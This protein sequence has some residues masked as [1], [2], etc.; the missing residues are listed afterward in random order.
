MAGATFVIVTGLGLAAFLIGRVDRFTPT[1]LIA[2]AGVAGLAVAV[3]SALSITQYRAIR[4]LD[5]ART[6]LLT[7]HAGLEIERNEHRAKIHDA[8]AMTAAMAAAAHALPE[9][10][11]AHEVCRA[12]TQ[13]ITRLQ[14]ILAAAPTGTL[15]AISLADLTGS[16]D[17]FA[18]LHRIEIIHDL[19][20]GAVLSDPIRLEQ[21][22]LNLLDNARKYAPGAPIDVYTEPAGPYVKLVVEDRGPGISPGDLEA[23]FLPGVR[24]AEATQGFGEGLAAARRVTEGMSGALW[25]E[26]RPGGGARFVL[27]LPRVADP[28][29]APA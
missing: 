14:E 4:Q 20:S 22:L 1:L 8:R 19:P 27:K 21:V 11:Q 12:L 23:L 5:E 13:Q 18:A 2:A 7:L 15:E 3:G 29:P 25:Y 26:A 24:R 10:D 28:D 9:I 6:E 17:R 16:L